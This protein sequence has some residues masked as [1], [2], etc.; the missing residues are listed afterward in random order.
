MSE[1]A[2][3]EREVAY[4]RARVEQLEA[5]LRGLEENDQ[6]AALLRMELKGRS[7]AVE[8]GSA[9]LRFLRD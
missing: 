3:L 6:G 1:K 4:H 2:V 8:I 7:A 5:L 9:R